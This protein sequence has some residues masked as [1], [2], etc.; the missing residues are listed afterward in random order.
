MC[1]GGVD[2]E[3]NSQIIAEDRCAGGEGGRTDTQH[4]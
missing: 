4:I 3:Q 1:E 2:L